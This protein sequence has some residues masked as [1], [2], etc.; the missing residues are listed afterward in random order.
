MVPHR[1]TEID[2][3]DVRADASPVV[4]AQS[5]SAFEEWVRSTPADE[6]AVEELLVVFSELVANAV[7]ASP[8]PQHEIEAAAWIEDERTIVLRVANHIVPATTKVAGP[9]LGDPLRTNG[10][11]LLIVRAY[12]D[13]VRTEVTDDTIAIRCER[14]LPG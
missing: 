8:T 5:R 3:F 6:D 4:V 14:R 7:H 2:R 10:R 1:T 12:T 13:T 11:G 9:D